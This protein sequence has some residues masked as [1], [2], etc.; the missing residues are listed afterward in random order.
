MKGATMA[1]EKEI[2]RLHYEG[3]SQRDIYVALRSG[4]TRVNA[5]IAEATKASITWEAVSV[6]DDSDIRTL[7]SPE[8]ER[9]SNFAEPDFEKL[10]KELLS[11]GVTRKLLW[12]DYCTNISELDKVPY[13][14]AQ[15]CRLFER[16]LKVNGAKMH[17]NHEPG[18]RM[19]VD[20]AG[21]N[22]E[23]TD[24][25]SGLIS[26]AW[27]FV[28]CLPYSD[29]IFAK[30]YPDMKQNSWQDGHI[31]AFEYYDGVPYIIVPDSCATAT[32]R[33]SIYLTLINDR[34]Y[35]F[36]AYHSTAIVPARVKRSNDKAL[37]ESAVLIC[38][39][40]IL[41]PLRHER[42]FSIAE[43]NEA[44]P[45]RLEAIND[46]P[47]Q[48]RDGSRSSVFIAE[49]KRLLKPLPSERYESAE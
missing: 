30:A 31:S 18:Q 4:H 17:L 40:Q 49:E 28:A 35:E 33:S 9:Q 44:I 41:A 11:P 32:N 20:W 26:R 46:T 29:I 38:E 13:G 8:S 10:T 42:F 14:Y 45:K 19:F 22:F 23:V 39:R 34:Y 16:H 27:L 47:F 2:L 7:L 48:K 12:H 43:L 37:V 6:M 3:M 36:A 15:F 25:L 1:K 21:K 24:A 5:L